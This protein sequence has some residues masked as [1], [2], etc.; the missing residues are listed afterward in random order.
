MCVRVIL[1]DRRRRS[2]HTVNHSAALQT[3]PN[4]PSRDHDALP[5]LTILLCSRTVVFAGRGHWLHLTLF[6]TSLARGAAAAA[7]VTIPVVAP[8]L[9]PA[10]PTEDPKARVGALINEGQA[11]FDTADYV[12]AIDLWT[13]AYAVLPDAPHLAAARNLLTYQ[14]AQAHIE[15]F[16]IDP[17]ASHLRKAERLLRQYIA[18]LDP[19][20]TEARVDAEQRLTAVE[21]RLQAVTP[22]RAAPRP[23]PPAPVPAPVVVIPSPVNRQRGPLLLLGGISLGLGG[24]LLISTALSATS[25]AAI[26]TERKLAHERGASPAE[27]DRLLARDTRADQATLATAIGGGALIATGIALV[28]KGSA[29]T[30]ALTAQPALTPGLLGARLNLRF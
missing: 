21:A 5:G 12:G 19:S 2:F 15:A 14:I 17:Q 9:E 4:P 11:L 3:G 22:P 25:S 18:A 26:D 23:T 20:E 8:P 29:R 6:A 30:R 10:E 16:A 13:A 27:L 28:V 24:A 7:P 1:V